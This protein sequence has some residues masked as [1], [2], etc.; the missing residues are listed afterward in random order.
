MIEDKA[1][2]GTE[3]QRRE[4]QRRARVFQTSA[5]H[6]TIVH[7]PTLHDDDDD[8]DSRHRPR[9][10]TSCLAFV[11]RNRDMIGNKVALLVCVLVQQGE[12]KHPSP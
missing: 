8:D 9:H 2:R 3:V 4:V 6:C 5:L 1:N 11:T 7:H 12:M 10:V